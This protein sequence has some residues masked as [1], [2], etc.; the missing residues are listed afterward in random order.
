MPENIHSFICR[1]D[2]K[3]EQFNALTQYTSEV[4]QSEWKIGEQ[5]GEGER[6][7]ETNQKIYVVL[8]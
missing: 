8:V 6:E 5:E 7:G 4:H 1:G 2:I 3:H